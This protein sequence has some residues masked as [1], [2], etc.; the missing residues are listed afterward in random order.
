[1]FFIH[2]QFI[3]VNILPPALVYFPRFSG[4]FPI[5]SVGLS[6]CI[7]EA[8][9]TGILHQGYYQCNVFCVFLQH[10]AGKLSKSL[11]GHNSQIH[12]AW[13]AGLIF[14]KH[15]TVPNLSLICLTISR[16][17]LVGNHSPRVLLQNRC[18]FSLEVSWEVSKSSK[19]VILILSAADIWLDNSPSW[20]HAVHGKMFSSIP[21]SRLWDASSTL[22]PARMSKNT[23]SHWSVFP[24]RSPFS[25]WWPL[26]S[27]ITVMHQVRTQCR[28]PLSNMLSSFWDVCCFPQLITHKRPRVS[29]CSYNPLV[30]V[31]SFDNKSQV[32]MA[33]NFLLGWW[34]NCHDLSVYTSWEEHTVSLELLCKPYLLA[35]GQGCKRP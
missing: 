14:A 35:E 5:S 2:R 16:K 1:M 4:K 33:R 19:P 34:R 22:R 17:C 32:D 31:W 24:G 13:T 23:F 7:Y 6:S 25:S 11:S 12:V 15:S 9:L 29:V 3:S 20:G 21:C 8:V 18:S 30:L 26:P 28:F 27:V 10:I